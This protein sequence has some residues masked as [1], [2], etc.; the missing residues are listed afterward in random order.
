MVHQAENLLYILED[1]FVH[2]YV[3]LPLKGE[4][5]YKAM[6]YPTIFSAYILEGYFYGSRPR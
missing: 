4:E 6:H 1:F 5:F 3:F 2:L